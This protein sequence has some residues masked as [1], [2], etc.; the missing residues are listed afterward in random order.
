MS[1]GASKSQYVK[2]ELRNICSARSEKQQQQQQQ[3]FKL[4]RQQQPQQQQS[5]EAMDFDGPSE[6]PLDILNT[7]KSRTCH[8]FECYLLSLKYLIFVKY[9]FA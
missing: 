8:F 2:Q 6:L 5:L 4:S 3:D 9:L 7:S 1:G